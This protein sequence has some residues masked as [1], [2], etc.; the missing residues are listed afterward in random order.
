MTLWLVLAGGLR[1]SWPM[2]SGDS[3]TL[4]VIGEGGYYSV[5]VFVEGALISTE[6][7]AAGD[8]TL[9]VFEG[10]ALSRLQASDPALKQYAPRL[11]LQLVET[12]VSLFADAVSA[13]LPQRLARRLMTQ[14]LASGRSA[15]HSELE[16]R[17]SQADLAAMLGASRSKVNAELR[18]LEEDGMIRL[19]Y[20]RLFILDC[21]R[22]SQRAGPRVRPL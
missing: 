8:T 2:P 19:G 1:V 16:I 20:R 4:A 7:T 14:A 10:D 17:V 15:S 21:A 18:R 5:G 6:C 13:P 11:M 12:A 3:V 22:L 9:A